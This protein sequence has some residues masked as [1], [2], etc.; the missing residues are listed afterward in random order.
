MNEQ[1]RKAILEAAATMKRQDRLIKHMVMCGIC[2]HAKI[3]DGALRCYGRGKP[4][5]SV[6]RNHT[7]DAFLPMEAEK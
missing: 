3:V 6:K 5:L 2:R 7:C 1:E 4:Y